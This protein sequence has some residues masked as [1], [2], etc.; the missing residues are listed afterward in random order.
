MVPGISGRTKQHN[1][2][3]GKE[4][5]FRSFYFLFHL[6]FP[7]QLLFNDQSFIGDLFINLFQ[8]NVVEFSP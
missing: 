6:T 2:E 4:M 8:N 3:G 7:T 1:S 5:H